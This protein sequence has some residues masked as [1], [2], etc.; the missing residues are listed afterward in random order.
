MRRHSDS[1]KNKEIVD[2]SEVKI[3]QKKNPV[4][5]DWDPVLVSEPRN[6]DPVTASFMVLDDLTHNI[7]HT[8][9]DEEHWNRRKGSRLERPDPCRSR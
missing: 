8:I 5:K 2:K 1:D 7:I 6:I 3:I 9:Y 4:I